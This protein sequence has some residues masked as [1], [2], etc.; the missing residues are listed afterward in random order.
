MIYKH[1]HSSISISTPLPPCTGIEH[2]QGLLLIN[3]AAKYTFILYFILATMRKLCIQTGKVLKI[4]FL[5]LNEL[6]GHKFQAP[7]TQSSLSPV[8]F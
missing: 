6:N 5:Y 7:T 3:E 8:F 4:C 2:E 1:F